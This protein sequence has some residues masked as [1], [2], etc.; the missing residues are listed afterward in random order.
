MA[1]STPKAKAPVRCAMIGY[2]GA[3]NMGAH[4]S[5]YINDIYGMEVTAVCDVDEARLAIFIFNEGAHTETYTDVD[6]M[7]KDGPVDLCVVIL[8]HNLHAPIALK[9][10]N[11]GKH[12]IL[13][14][15]MCLNVAEATSMIEAAKE[16]NTMLTVYHNRRHD[17]DFRTINS[18]VKDGLIG[19]V[20]HIEMFSGGYSG[21]GS[22]WR[23]SKEVSGGAFFDW[24]AHFL[25][26]LM[27]VMGERKMVNVTGFF[28]KEIWDDNTNEDHVQAIIRFDDGAMADVTMSHM[29]R[30]GKPKWFV[31]GTKGA[32]VDQGGSFKLSSE[33]GGY[34]ADAIINYKDGTH[35]LYYQQIAAHLLKGEELS[36]KP[37]QARRTIAIMEMAEKSSKSGQAEPVPY[38]DSWIPWSE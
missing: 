31:L 6:E 21:H 18:I 23:G 20:H 27:Q 37:E 30:A 29:A 4:H 5:G 16:S 8:P 25:D 22:W 15:P 34:P 2:G 26:W 17:G 3:F 10:L 38:E 12:V 11:A 7:L 1:T 24:G 33:I 14:K 9:C 35:D 28:R 13:E 36:V 19:D 32:A